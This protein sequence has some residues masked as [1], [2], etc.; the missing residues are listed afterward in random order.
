MHIKR[1][2][3]LEKSRVWW[4]Y[5][6][7]VYDEGTPFA[8]LTLN[9]QSPI[10]RFQKPV[11]NRKSQA[12]SMGPGY[13]SIWFLGIKENGD[14]ILRDWMEGS[15]GNDTLILSDVGREIEIRVSMIEEPDNGITAVIPCHYE[16]S[17][18]NS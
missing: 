14:L 5:S 4:G 13:Q 17:H 2:S 16:N 1:G 12:G 11:D 10:V 8:L 15:T 3:G 9:I 18:V 7:E 6:L